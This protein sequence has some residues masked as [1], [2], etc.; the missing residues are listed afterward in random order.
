MRA[1]ICASVAAVAITVLASSGVVSGQ[2]NVLRIPPSSLA[3]PVMVFPASAVNGAGQFNVNLTD[4]GVH[5][6]TTGGDINAGANIVIN[7]GS[8]T[9][10]NTNT[11]VDISGR[12]APRQYSFNG[13]GAVFAFSTAPTATTFCT[14]PSIPNNNGTMAFTVNVGTACATS[15]GTITL[16]AA[17]TGWVVNCH[18][19]T[20][21]AT[22][23]VEQTGGTTT[24]ATVTNY[25]RTTGVAGSWTDSNVLRCNAVAY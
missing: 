21:P 15:V 2:T 12:V 9:S 3:P 18:N 22:N 14:S 24:T 6:I 1:F 20:A 8:I 5:T 19:V 25:V 10:N 13:I 11:V 16:P 17:T 23:I 4:L 7:S